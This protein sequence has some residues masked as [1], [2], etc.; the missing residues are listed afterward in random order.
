MAEDKSEGWLSG[1][2]ASSLFNKLA[3]GAVKKSV[4]PKITAVGVSSAEE[5][6][7]VENWLSDPKTQGF[8][9]R[10]NKG[11]HKTLGIVTGLEH[12][13]DDVYVNYMDQDGNSMGFVYEKGD[14]KFEEAPEGFKEGD[15]IL[16]DFEHHLKMK[17]VKPVSY[18]PKTEKKIIR[19]FMQ[20]LG[21][22]E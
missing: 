17:S 19:R 15:L 21:G 7:A 22:R 5:Q 20:M 3:G 8:I 9:E 16:N 2:S 6:I 18:P 12:H 10:H 14:P 11:E 13:G 4:E 1:D